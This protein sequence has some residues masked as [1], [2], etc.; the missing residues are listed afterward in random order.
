MNNID[1]MSYKT[2][3]EI[4]ILVDYYF[5]DQLLNIVSD[6]MTVDL[7]NSIMNPIERIRL[8]GIINNK[9]QYASFNN[10]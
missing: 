6:S 4:S 10:Q 2:V 9:L 3:S 5:R 7:W 8:Q 1:K